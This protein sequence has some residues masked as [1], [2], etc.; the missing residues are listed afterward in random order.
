MAN[1]QYIGARYVP[2]FFLNPDDQSNDWK[3][4][5]LYEAFTI[6]TYNN[7][8]YTSKVP[9]PATVGDPASNPEY[10][11][12][13]TKYT[14]ALMALQTTV[15]NI[16][17]FVNIAPLDTDAQT[18]S[19]GINELF[20][21]LNVYTLPQLYGAVADGV[22][23]DTQ[24]VTDCINNA[25]GKTVFFPSGTYLIDF[26][27]IVLSNIKLLG[28]NENATI[29]KQRN[30][31]KP[32]AIVERNVE[33]S[34]LSIL[35]ANNDID[36]PVFNFIMYNGNRYDCRYHNIHDVKVIGGY[37]HTTAFLFNAEYGGSLG[38]IM[39]DILIEGC[40][41]GVLIEGVGTS[42]SAIPW[43][44]DETMTNIFISNPKDYGFK[45][46]D[47]SDTNR[48]QLSHSNFDNITVR[49]F[50]NTC[51]GISL[52]PNSYNLLNPR[53]FNDASGAAP[54]GLELV[55]GNLNHSITRQ[56]VLPNITYA[57]IEGR[58]DMT[59]VKYF[60]ITSAMIATRDASTDPM[61]YKKIIN[62]AY[63]DN[64]LVTG[65]NVA[66]I[67]SATYSG[68]TI[69]DLSNYVSLGGDLV[70]AQAVPI[71]TSSDIRFD[72]TIYSLTN[73][74]VHPN[75]SF[76]GVLAV[77]YATRGTDT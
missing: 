53:I 68:G 37:D 12:C 33:I 56:R 64:Q 63:I 49:M 6:V 2:K 27:A 17:A 41:N 52:M 15:G 22:T 48:F 60:N 5:V 43:L 70:F 16:D 20:K 30:K 29:I 25:N 72:T 32:F 76:T 66:I 44:T 45:I 14:A 38:G 55:K 19:G 23:D 8:S 47:N 46:A 18:L 40:Q 73:I 4:G 71:G 61:Q 13:T 74:A 42:D 11:A 26:D 7:D 59:A 1:L 75:T 28:E 69:I 3:S 62:N 65:F 54:L 35:A 57:F 34:D 67:P 24:A 50:S 10:W 51:T 36:T 9:V 39:T 31:N 21:Y 77:L 58:L